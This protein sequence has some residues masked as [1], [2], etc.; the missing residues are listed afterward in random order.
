[1]LGNFEKR[2]FED[3]K[4]VWIGRYKNL[5]NLLHWHFESEIITV[6]KGNAKIKIGDMLF[7]ANQGDSFLTHSLQISPSSSNSF[8]RYLF[9]LYAFVRTLA[10][11]FLH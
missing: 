5:I 6:K 11:Q 10:I 2:R 3:G 9:Q 8:Q 7:N 1:M 4:K